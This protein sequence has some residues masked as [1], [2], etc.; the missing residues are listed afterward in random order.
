MQTVVGEV[1]RQRG[2]PVKEFVF[3]NPDT[4]VETAEVRSPA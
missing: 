1:A 4:K 3:H 2:V